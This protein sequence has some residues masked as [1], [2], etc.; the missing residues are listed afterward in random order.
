[1]NIAIKPCSK[2]N[3]GIAARSHRSPVTAA[4]TSNRN[5]MV[6]MQTEKNARIFHSEMI[7]QESWEAAI[8]AP[9][10]EADE[11]N[12]NRRSI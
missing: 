11:R 3:I 2:P 6:L 8:D 10:I 4:H 5:R 1:L 12:L 7:D 9:V